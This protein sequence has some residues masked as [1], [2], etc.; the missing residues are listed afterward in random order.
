M[1]TQP[2]IIIIGGRCAGASL[3]LRLAEQN[4][5][6]LVVDRATFPSLPNVPSSPAIYAG[7]MHLLDELG[8]DEAEYTYPDG[9]ADTL[10]MFAV[11]HFSAI[12]PTKHAEIDRHYVYG[13]D[14]TRFDT[15]LWNRAAA[16]P[17]ITACQ[18]FTVT[19]ITKDADGRATGIVGKDSTGAEV[20]ATARLVVG[21]DGRFS[22]TAREVGA[23]VVEEHNGQITSSYHAE[24][25]NV[26]P[27]SSD[28][29]RSLSIYNTMAGFAVL[30]IPIN[31]RKYIVGTYMQSSMSNFG[32]QN[33]ETAYIEGLKSIPKA[34]ERLKNAEKVTSVV[35]VKGIQNGYR[36]PYGKGWALVGDA[37]HYK[38]P[39]DGQG[40]YDALLGAKLLAQTIGEWQADEPWEQAGQRYQDALWQAT[41][42]MFLQTV[43]RIKQEMFSS[44]PKFIIKT[45]IRWTLTDPQYQKGF[46]RYLHRAIEPKDRPNPNPSIILR[47]IRRDLTR[48]NG[49]KH[50]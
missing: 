47:G 18:D 40:I 45:L 23:Q 46:L 12:I 13:I 11:N 5:K 4:L 28:V 3:A 30:F 8:L 7:A 22:W 15:A 29:P 32:G 10:V 49:A 35:G 17:N 33:L 37:A 42:E 20:K 21:A 27:F 24:W 38:D 31:T 9:R 36:Q 6:V 44:P 43:G 16:H 19:S 48:R 26:D 41:H 50:T 34:W 2:D 39:I 25:E 1:E 14:R